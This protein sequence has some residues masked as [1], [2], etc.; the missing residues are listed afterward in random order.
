MAG[1]TGFGAANISP[2]QY[3][4]KQ[5]PDRSEMGWETGKTPYTKILEQPAENKLRF[6]YEC[7]GRSAGS[8]HG[9]NYTNDNRSYPRI[10]VVG[11]RGPAVVV[12]SCV[13]DQP[14]YRAHPHNLVGKDGMCKKGV[15]SMTIT[16]ADMTISFQN[17]GIQCVRRKDAPASL[18]QR[19]QILVDPFKQGFN[20]KSSQINLNSLRLCFQVV[21]NTVFLGGGSNL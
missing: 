15:C 3:P 8:L 20:H 1:L 12:V 13:E 10:Q 21:F 11:Y 6:R 5:D 9:V 4:V 2:S 16:S 18:Q 14:P 17:L 19:E 7:E